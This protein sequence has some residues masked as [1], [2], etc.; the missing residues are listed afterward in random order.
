MGVR[1]I[2]KNEVLTAVL[3]GEIDHHSAREIRSEIDSTATKVKPK[4][5]A[6]DFSAVSFMD[7]SGIGLARSEER[8][9]GRCKLMHLWGGEVEIINLPPNLERIVSLAGLGQLCTIRKE[10][11]DEADE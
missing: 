1:L 4:K 8:R 9:V 2:L 10:N 11:S 6:L 5:L 3:S 7:S